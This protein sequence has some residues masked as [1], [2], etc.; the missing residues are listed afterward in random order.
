MTSLEERLGYGFR[1]PEL[2]KRALTTPARR[3]DHPAERDN[4]RLEFLGDAVMGLLSADAV[5]ADHPDEEEGR[6]TVRRSRLVSTGAL[7]AAAEK[8]GLRSHLL[9]NAGAAPLPPFAKALTDALEAVMG[10]VWLDGGLDAARTVFRR[11]ELPFAD[12]CCPWREIPKGALQEISQ[13]MHPPRQPVYTLVSRTGPAHAPVHTVTAA[14]EG[15]GEATASATSRSAA[16]AAAAA[17][18]IETS[19]KR[20]LA[21]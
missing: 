16:E 15:L 14:V 6:L 10:A 4:Q 21:K 18:L 8:L 20:S 1:N 3:M 2:L 9:R 19:R 7:A 12:D 11:L 13:A 17:A 5:F